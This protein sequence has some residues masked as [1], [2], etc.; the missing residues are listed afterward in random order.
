VSDRIGLGVISVANQYTDEFKAQV[1]KE[2]EEVGNA[3]LV[4]RRYELSKNTVYTW[5]RAARKRGSTET[6]SR[7]L[8]SRTAELE[9]RLE[10]VSRENEQ[11]K[12]LIAEKELELVILRELRDKINPR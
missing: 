2:V 5:M 12:R 10:K 11:L 3:A 7:G 8:Q 9:K 4:A 6:L 1:L